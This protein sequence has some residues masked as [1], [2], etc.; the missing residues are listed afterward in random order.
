MTKVGPERDGVNRTTDPE[1]H[2]RQ[3]PRCRQGMA[4]VRELGP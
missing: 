4:G 2:R 3:H 1:D